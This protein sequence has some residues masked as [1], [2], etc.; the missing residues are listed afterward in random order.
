MCGQ[1]SLLSVLRN[2]TDFRKVLNY[3]CTFTFAPVHR[4]GDMMVLRLPSACPSR[5]D[6]WS[7]RRRLC[8]WGFRQCHPTGRSCQKC[9]L[10]L[11]PGPTVS[12][13]MWI[14]DSSYVALW[15]LVLKRKWRGLIFLL[16]LAR[17]VSGW[18]K[19]FV[20][21]FTKLI[22]ICV[23]MRLHVMSFNNWHIHAQ[24]KR[25]RLGCSSRSSSQSMLL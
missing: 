12:W 14:R 17:G 7:N 5:F 9:G 15:V 11:C 20:W 25:M 2:L 6:F 10:V 4:V 19:H 18:S 24:W 16:A 8:S 22:G 23:V 21:K 1:Q 3:W 13:T